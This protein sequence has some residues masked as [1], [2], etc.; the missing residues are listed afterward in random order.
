M[1]M[2]MSLG[3]AASDG[4]RVR[5]D[6]VRTGRYEAVYWRPFASEN[7]GKILFAAELFD[8]A[9]KKR[10]DHNGPLGHI[11]RD[12]LRELTRLVDFR[13][14][15][16]EPSLKAL[17]ERSG[18]SKTSVVKALAAL[19]KHGF[20]E[21]IRRYEPFDNPGKGPQLRQVTNAYRLKLPPKALRFL[22]LRNQPPPPPVDDQDRRRQADRDFAQAIDA[23]EPEARN[24]ALIG[25]TPLAA[26][27]SSLERGVT[28]ASSYPGQ[29]TV[30]RSIER[31][32]WRPARRGTHEFER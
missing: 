18:H 11:G 2:T 6:S 12:V 20:I 7:V 23:L 15:R 9:L 27:L 3:T 4:P 32:M 16:L 21:W 14:G 19:K 10:G 5:R 17:G 28:N 29:E 25:D 30:S 1:S 8:R 24:R 31:E 13:T 22:G 26:A